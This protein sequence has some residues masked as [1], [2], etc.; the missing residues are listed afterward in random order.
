MGKTLPEAPLIQALAG[1]SQEGTV[2]APGLDGVPRLFAFAPLAA[3]GSSGRA[4]LAIGIPESVAFQSADAGL[5]RN[6]IALA[7]VAVLALGAVWIGG[8]LFVL[9]PVRALALATSQVADGNFETR[10]GPRYPP[11]ELGGLA[12]GFDIMS[13]ALR[14][15]VAALRDAEAGVRKERDELSSH[16]YLLSVLLS[17]SDL[18]ERAGLVLDT[19]MRLGS[20]D[21]GMVYLTRKDDVAL[22]M[23]R[24]ITPKLRT[25][26]Q[27]YP[28]TPT[29]SWLRN[30]VVIRHGSPE[31]QQLPE[32]AREEVVRVWAGL[33]LVLPA[34]EGAA[35]GQWIG[36]V[37]LASRAVDAVSPDQAK[38]LAS[39]SLQ[40]ALAIKNATELG[41]SRPPS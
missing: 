40:L 15:A 1:Q 2:E 11:G 36:P 30:A 26:I 17:T 38:A 28:L 31:F 29:P 3:T 37:V 22:Y 13:G 25:A 21:M 24:G 33:P 12:R 32:E 34:R 27:A 8:G 5:R 23:A 35:E 7:V 41:A 9:R 10:F 14:T 19:L 16:V 39:M 4:T 18:R 20:A 6:L